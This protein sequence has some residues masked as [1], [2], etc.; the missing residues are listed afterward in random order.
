MA[1]DDPEM[2]KSG[3]QHQINTEHFFVHTGR[4]ERYSHLINALNNIC[5]D[6]R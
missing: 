1:A 3:D 6:P 5:L 4:V 2:C